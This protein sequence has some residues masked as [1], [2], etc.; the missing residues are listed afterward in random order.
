MKLMELK[1]KNF[2]LVLKKLIHILRCLHITDQKLTK[3]TCHEKTTAHIQGSEVKTKPKIAIIGL[4]NTAPKVFDAKNKSAHRKLNQKRLIK[5]NEK[6]QKL[7]SFSYLNYYYLP[8][9]MTMNCGHCGTKINIKG[10]NPLYRTCDAYV[11]SPA[12]SRARMQVITKLD[13]NLTQPME[14]AS[15]TTLNPPKT[16]ERKQSYIGL[17]NLNLTSEVGIK[18]PIIDSEKEVP[19]DDPGRHYYVPI[20]PHEPENPD[21][22]PYNIMDTITTV[23][24]TVFALGV[25]ILAT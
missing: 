1:I 18:M 13:P 5:V 17:G 16:L 9:T 11:C 19:K 6:I 12:C 25:F 4:E 22:G 10:W 14:W 20:P 7:I 24:M 23:C 15:T 3:T 2:L 8:I 21:R